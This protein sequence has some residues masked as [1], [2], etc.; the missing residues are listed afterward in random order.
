MFTLIFQCK[1][2]LV[3]NFPIEIRLRFRGRKEEKK[4]KGKVEMFVYEMKSFKFDF[5]DS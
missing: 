5:H 4:E 2:K 3:N 1:A